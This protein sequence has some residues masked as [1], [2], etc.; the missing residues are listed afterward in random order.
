MLESLKNN[1]VQACENEKITLH[2]PRNTHILVENSFYGR[3]VPSSELCPLPGIGPIKNEDTSCDVAEAH[4]KI[5]DLCRNKRKC[6]IVVKPS[7]FDHDP[8]PN[9][10]K[11]LQISYK[12][13]PI[14]FEDQNFCEGTNMQLSCKSNKRLAIYSANYGRTVNGQAEMHCPLKTPV[15]QDCVADVLP[16]ILEKCHAQTECTIAVNDHFLGNPCE[17]E[18][19]KYL[20]LIFMCV[21]DE[22]FSEAAIKGNLDSMKELKN[23]LNSVVGLHKNTNFQ[24]SMVKDEAPVMYRPTMLHLDSRSHESLRNDAAFTQSDIVHRPPSHVEVHPD[25][26]DE[27][28]RIHPAREDEADEQRLPNAVGVAHDF[29]VLVEFLKENKE[30]T[31]LYFFLSA[32]TGIILLLLACICQQCRAKSREDRAEKV[33]RLEPAK[34]AELSSL[35][36]SNHTSPM[37]LDSD[38]RHM[39]MGELGS[40][41]HYMRFSQIT[42]PRIQPYI[43]Y[44]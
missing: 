36:G 3:L 12:C 43:Y 40:D 7:F 35:I 2:C 38:S 20:S 4:A 34:S 15:T 39:D 22:V 23:E 14:S 21:N 28:I 16:Q 11:Y 25:Y 33:V 13:K 41:G 17:N 26:P 9:T 44:S 27:N 8:C 42:P 6:R 30:K 10:S 24:T 18:V 1:L 29:L 19:Q 37:Y 31:L 32:S 5:T